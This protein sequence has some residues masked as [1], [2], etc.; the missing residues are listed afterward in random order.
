MNIEILHEG[1]LTFEEQRKTE[2]CQSE[3]LEDF[4]SS[5]D[6]NLTIE[7]YPAPIRILAIAE[8]KS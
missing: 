8:K 1:K 7:G 6:P 4:T 3:S 5:D 2:W